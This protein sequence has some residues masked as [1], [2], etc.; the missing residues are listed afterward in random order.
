MI[1]PRTLKDRGVSRR[2]L[3]RYAGAGL[4]AAAVA[5]VLDACTP[6]TGSGT[7]FSTST[8]VKGGTLRAG[9]TG[10]GA[11]ATLDAATPLNNVDF[12]RVAAL[13]NP[14]IVMNKDA[15]GVNAL[16]E[17][18]EPSADAMSW[19]IRLK[20]GLT[21]HNG[22]SVTADDVLFTLNRVASN[23]YGGSS[24]LT[25]V[26]MKNAQKLDELT[27]KLP[28][29]APYAILDQALYANAYY[30]GIVPT[31]YDPQNPVGTGP[32][33]FQSFTPGQQSVFA[34]NTDYWDTAAYVDSLVI[35]NYADETAQLNALQSQQVDLVNQ[36][37]AASTGIAQA[38]GQ[39]LI[40]QGGAPVPI[41]MRTDKAPYNDV[42]VRQA[43]R[44]L[45]DRA[46]MNS[47]VFD[48]NGTVG[49]D[50]FGIWDPDYDSSL[51]QREQDIEQ[52]KSLLK[53]AGQSDL[54]IT[55]TVGD[56]G[57]GAVQTAQVFADQAK[58]A[59]V[60]V[61]IQKVTVTDYFGSNFLSWDLSIDPWSYVPYLPMAGYTTTPGAP[62]PET[63]FDNAQYNS[64]YAQAIGTV[65][66]NAR[67]ELSHEMQLIDYNEGG[68][69]VPQFAAT[70]DAAGKS[71]GGLTASKTGLSFGDF[72]FKSM[73]VA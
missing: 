27:V 30:L 64:L 25:Q 71:V 63:H 17:L 61:D 59:G 36:L 38:T 19:T 8:P 40:S 54:Q 72:D 35:S 43:L 49:N 34:A 33:T 22:K 7:A 65:D 50:V 31:D 55:F 15:I 51:P 73:W 58:Q 23:Q 11:A 13:Y 21:F 42:R 14:L 47:V 3:F 26:D 18:I 20:D 56:V 52:A 66:E 29:F 39:V 69:I 9:L 32:F 1:E 16:A 48:G 37:S 44:L 6:S 62:Y 28:C 60:T 10:G 5:G 67:R 70:I 45:V 53:Q 4:A 24:A 46:Q 41:V 68:Y 12:A 57:N 2:D